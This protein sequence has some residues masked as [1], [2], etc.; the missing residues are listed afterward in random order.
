M[1]VRPPTSVL[2]SLNQLLK[3]MHADFSTS[4]S[5][6]L[7]SDDRYASALFF[8]FKDSSISL[9]KTRECFAVV[10]LQ[11]LIDSRE[12]SIRIPIICSK[13]ISTLRHCFINEETAKHHDYTIVG[14]LSTTV[15]LDPGLD[16]VSCILLIL[17]QT[18]HHG[19][20]SFPCLPFRITR[21]MRIRKRRSMNT[22]HMIE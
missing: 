9:G 8:D 3:G 21:R 1:L 2:R 12:T 20:N 14:Y 13:D 4:L 6:S 18:H 15:V 10:W 22:R 5:F 16:E 17:I 11:A 7:R 19:S